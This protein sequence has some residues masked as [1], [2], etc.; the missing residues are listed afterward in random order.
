MYMFPEGLF[1]GIQLVLVR[2]PFQ[3]WFNVQHRHARP[4]MHLTGVV[5][6]FDPLYIL[7]DPAVHVLHVVCCPQLLAQFFAYP[8]PVQG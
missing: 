1:E 8:E 6:S 2:D 4:P 5:P 7:L 3:S